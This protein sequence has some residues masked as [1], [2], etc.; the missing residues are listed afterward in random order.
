MITI[1]EKDVSL[2]AHQF[3]DFDGVIIN[4]AELP[5]ST[6]LFTAELTTLLASL[7]PFK[8]RLVWL[9]LPIDKAA[10]VGIVAGFGFVFHNCLEQ[11]VTMILRLAPDAYAPFVPT[12]S[13]GSGALV[14]N[15]KNQIL[16]VKEIKQPGLGY[17][18]PGGHIELN[19]NIS[20]AILR[21]VVEETGVV[22]EFDSL[23]GF[24]IKHNYRFSKSNIYFVCKLN[25]VSEKIDIQDT[26]EIEDAKWMDVESYLSD[27]SSSVFNRK[28]VATLLTTEGFRLTELE[29][30]SGPNAKSEVYFS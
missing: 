28:M 7:K 9:T 2:L 22:T 14:L 5:N 25:V 1:H 21:E 24:A 16:L 11:E 20:Q 12:H 30:N 17:K 23:V 19:E 26:D 18:L 29:Y 6:T 15:D 3:D 10:W 13:I 8:K 4:T 27:D